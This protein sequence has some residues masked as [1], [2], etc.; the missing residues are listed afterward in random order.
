M[1]RNSGYFLVWRK[2]WKSPVFKNLK[3]CAIWIY[4]ISQATY[5]D[6]TLNFLD[7]KIFIKKAELI[8]PLR[9]NAEIW[10]ITYSEMRTFIKRLKN[11]KMINV[12]IHHLTPTSNHPS[13]KVSIIECLNYDKY[14]YLENVQPPEH[15]LSPDTNTYNTNTNI[16]IGSSKNV[17]NGYKTIGEWG[18]YTILEKNGKK[19][20]RHKFKKEAIKP[21]DESNT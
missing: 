10:G 19:Y 11:R 16:S 6:K 20:Q 8:F 3:Q 5:K 9:K 21:Y 12:R 2:I 15:Q 18:H 13:R 4:M 14:Q 7:N 17:N 1:E